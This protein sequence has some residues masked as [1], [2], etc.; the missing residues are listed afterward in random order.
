MYLIAISS[1]SQG[2]GSL[3]LEA[4]SE[5]LEILSAIE[6][7]TPYPLI[8]EL[9]LWQRLNTVTACVISCVDHS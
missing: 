5:K 8:S 2:F 4:G 3:K 1:Y 9:R 7:R 6:S